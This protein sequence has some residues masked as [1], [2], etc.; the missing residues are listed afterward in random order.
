MSK[1][2]CVLVILDGYGISDK[3]EGNAVCKANT[4]NIDRILKSYPN[5]S[6]YASGLKVGLP[7]G[8]MG[9]SEV[10]HLNIGAGR[11][12]YQELT[13]ITKE[14]E[15]GNFFNNESLNAA[16]D[17]CLKNKSNLHVMGLVSDGGVHSHI[18][19]LKAVIKLAKDRGV[20]TTLVHCFM[21]GR[22]V[23]PTSGAG[24]MEELLSYM[25]EI[26]YGEVSTISGRYYS[27][28][29]D[30]RWDRVESCYNAIV[31]GIGEEKIGE[32]P[33]EV[34]K[35]YYNNGITDEFILP[36]IIKKDSNL[37]SGDSCIF[38]NF[39]PDRARQLT[40]AIVDKNFEHFKTEDI[41]LTF[42]CMTVFDKNLKGVLVAF[43]PE[44]YPNTLGEYLSKNGKTQLR[45]AETEKY[46]HVTFFFSGGVETSYEG[47]DRI[48]IP[49][50]NVKTYDLK[51][52]MSLPELTDNLIEQIESRKYDVIVCNIANS[53]MVG[54]TGDF[55][56]AVKAVEA[57]DFAIGKIEKK[58]LEHGDIMFITA[59]HGN[60]ESMVDEKGGPVTSHT[61]N[62]VPFI[63]VSGKCDG[64][65][66]REEGKL[67]DIAPTILTVM[68][69]EIP[70]EISGDN[71][72]YNTK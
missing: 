14:I 67:A 10:G 12:I 61:C 22:D 17:N 2:S 43:K 68:G 72:V 54:H 20:G 60:V 71:L 18:N 6:L 59:D 1:N 34:I 53:D 36:T 26:S 52:E 49:S 24:Y 51:P 48:L 47:E 66:L 16:I 64:I 69:M 11:I 25:K 33:V 37:K 45:I 5:T 41:N 31:K 21:D 35:N 30:K 55:D 58:V 27:M 15:D 9:N 4:V 32:D 29:R 63:Y 62:K 19:H 65:K 39:R 8:Q 42:V 13:R 57:V 40:Y 50:P 44:N 46:A 28:D 70:K 23:S 3:K 7:E 38:C 56:A